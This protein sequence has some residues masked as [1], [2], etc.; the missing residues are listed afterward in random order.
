[1]TSINIQPPVLDLSLYAGDGVGFRL[2]CT[3]EAGAPVPLTGT[4]EAQVRVDRLTDDLAIVEFGADLTNSG[5]GIVVLSLTGVQT[6][7][8]VDHPSSKNGKFTGVWDVEWV[9]DS[10]EPRTLCQGKVE[11]LPDV[12]R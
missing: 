10:A 1:M 3:D 9:G 11:C 12:T 5:D 8:L 7:T 6:Q 4:V 2:I